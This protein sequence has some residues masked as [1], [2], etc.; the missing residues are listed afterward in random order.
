M[1]VNFKFDGD[2]V[3]KIGK[4]SW[5]IT[6]AVGIAG[7]KT[8]VGQ[9]VL[10][11]VNSTLDGDFNAVKKINLDYVIGEEKPKSDKPKK[12][13]FGKKQKDDAQELIDD[14]TDEAVEAKFEEAR[15]KLDK[16]EK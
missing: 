13:W 14:I 12:K 4:T 5:R 6:K 3:K 1:N 2:T 8:L 16:L 15:Q 10:K 9:A 11:T 7:V